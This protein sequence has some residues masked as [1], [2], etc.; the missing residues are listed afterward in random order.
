M[1]TS[2]DTIIE[3]T[4]TALE[5]ILELRT[6]E[7]IPDLHLGLRIAG[8][9][10]QGFIYETAFVRPEDVNATDHLEDHGGLPVAIAADSV[11]NLR[12]SVLDLSLDPTA[13]GLVLRNPNPA[14]P[15][16]DL[17]EIELDGTVEERISQLLDQ[18]INP[19]IAGHGG[20]VRLIGVDGGEAHLEMGGGCQGCGL[21]AMT[22]RQGIETAIRDHIPEITE[23][24]DATDHT[25]GANPYY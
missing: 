17:G 23:I 7:A 22:L 19:A 18:Q 14:T 16:M 5:Q 6:G 15:T 20:W 8:V 2:T 9:G 10:T 4:P 11:E 3:I 1:D 24:I 21:A 12:N 25:A 13:P